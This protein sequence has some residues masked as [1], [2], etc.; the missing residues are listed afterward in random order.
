MY[1]DHLSNIMEDSKAH[2]AERERDAESA[3]R[4]RAGSSVLGTRTWW[5][6][7][8]SLEEI[9]NMTQSTATRAWKNSTTTFLEWRTQRGYFYVNPSV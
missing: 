4:D 3:V 7:E 1:Q 8:P 9:I 6:S 2:S 5:T